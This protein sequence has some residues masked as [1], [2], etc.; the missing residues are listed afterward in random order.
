M[1]RTKQQKIIQ[2]DID[3][4]TCRRCSRLKTHHVTIFRL[5]HTIVY[6]CHYSRNNNSSTLLTLWHRRALLANQFQWSFAM[7][8]TE[9]WVCSKLSSI[10]W[11]LEDDRQLKSRLSCFVAWITTPSFIHTR[12]VGALLLRMHLYLISKVSK[13]LFA[14]YACT[15]VNYGFYSI[16]FFFSFRWSPRLTRDQW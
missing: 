14:A 10:Q 9:S 6:R 8:C 7:P 13:R 4:Q 5:V 1:Q 11:W 2:A 3:K 16:F 12:T 15:E